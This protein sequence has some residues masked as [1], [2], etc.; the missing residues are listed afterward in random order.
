M[1]I[2]HPGAGRQAKKLATVRR[3]QLIYRLLTILLPLLLLLTAWLLRSWLFS[4]LNDVLPAG[5]NPLVTTLLVLALVLALAL[6][7]GWLLDRQADQHAFSAMLLQSG[8]DGENDA[9][10]LLTPLP[11]DYHLFPNRLITGDNQ[12]AEFD[13]IVAGPNGVTI[14]EVKNHKGR[15]TG[16]AAG[17]QLTL[18]HPNGRR[19]HFD[20][21]IR[22]A[23][24]QH[25]VLT[26]HLRNVGIE[27]KIN[28]CVLFTNPETTVTLHDPF[29]ATEY[30]RVFSRESTDQLIQLITA[31]GSMPSGHFEHLVD[32][33]EDLT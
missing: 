18:V 5:V 17:K 1:A 16:F 3:R 7:T 23:G 9:L 19:R 12:R 30:T 26:A 33:L 20:N 11:D 31:P 6:L 14:V 22:Q 27:A 32:M 8:V 29:G 15:V 25:T 13:L 28:R 10:A 24:R 4:A 21:P 2:I